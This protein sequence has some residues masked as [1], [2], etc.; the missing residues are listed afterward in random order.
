[1]AAKKDSKTLE[2]PINSHLFTKVI[3]GLNHFA[4]TGITT[5]C[6]FTV[7]FMGTK[8]REIPNY[9]EDYFCYV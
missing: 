6:T 3:S 5:K 1:M 4:I 9:C 8:C 2:N 7:K